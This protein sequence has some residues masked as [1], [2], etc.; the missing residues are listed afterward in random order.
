MR[1]T[2]AI[3]VALTVALLLGVFGG[4]ALSKLGATAFAPSP[5]VHADHAALLDEARAER[6]LFTLSTCPFCRDARAWLGQHRID[7]V[8][9]E[10][11]T[12]SDAQRLFARLGE[13]ALPV[14]VGRDRRVRGYVPAAY[15]EWLLADAE[16]AAGER[17]ATPHAAIDTAASGVAQ[18]SARTQ[19]AARVRSH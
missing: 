17:P 11:D 18:R 8:E 9:L 10:V 4:R 12:S 6:I 5:V 16:P 19:P 7:H 14:L 15:A 3:L 2:L 1:R 13:P